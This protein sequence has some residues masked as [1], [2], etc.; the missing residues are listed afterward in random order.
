MTQF[1]FKLLL[2]LL[3]SGENSTY[4]S[5]ISFS[6]IHWVGMLRSPPKESNETYDEGC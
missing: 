1:K 6:G 3:A 2:K 5:H 4:D